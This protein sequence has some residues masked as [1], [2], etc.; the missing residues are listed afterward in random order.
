MTSK[1]TSIIL[2]NNIREL[3]DR[4]SLERGQ[5]MTAIIEEAVIHYY[6]HKTAE[7]ARAKYNQFIGAV[8]QIPN[9]FRTL[10]PLI[11]ESPFTFGRYD[12]VIELVEKALSGLNSE[13]YPQVYQAG[14]E[15]LRILADLQ[16]MIS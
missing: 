2:N 1:M 13:K 15:L 11:E 9:S 3:I 14:E 7:G 10:K 16:G 4:M 8:A 12:K 6:E 5:S